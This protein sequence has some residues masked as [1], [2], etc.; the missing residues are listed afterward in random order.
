VVLEKGPNIKTFPKFGPL[1][2]EAQVPVLLKMGD[3]ISTDEIMKAGVKVLA[4][5]SNIPEISRWAFAV[6]DETFY[7]RAVEARDRFGGHVVVAG[8]NYAQGSSREHAAIAPRYL[9]QVAVVAK[10]YA[11]LGWQN[12]VNFGI[13]PFEFAHAIDYDTIEQGDLIRLEGIRENLIHNRTQIAHNLT[14]DKQYEL[15][16][17]LSERQVRVLT[18]GGVI[19]YFSMPAVD[20]RSAGTPSAT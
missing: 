20:P 13:V 14:R 7:D 15:K 8:E 3:N 19:N 4:F 1:P 5:R 17:N 11:R 10:S 2:E 18:A 9:G 6:V 12:L 16:H